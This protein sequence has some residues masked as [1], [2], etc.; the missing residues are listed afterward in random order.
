MAARRKGTEVSLQ[1]Y[2]E[3]LPATG[4]DRRGSPRQTLVLGSRIGACGTPVRI[5][6][7]SA[8]GL[9]I[10]SAAALMPGEIVDVELPEAGRTEARV[11]RRDG[12]RAGCEFLQPLSKA[13]LSAAFL[14]ADAAPPLVFRPLAPPVRRYGRAIGATVLL[15]LVGGALIGS[16]PVA[17]LP[18]L[19]AAVALALLAT[20]GMWALD[21]EL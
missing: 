7:L 15:L 9:M 16:G 1:A 11:V 5:H 18:L 4:G 14:R 2:F 3:A 19:A 20:W 13:V 10:E 21:H 8:S 12:D 6:D 17:P